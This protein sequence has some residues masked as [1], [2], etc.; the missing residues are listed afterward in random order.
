MN[1]RKLSEKDK[2]ELQKQFPVIE[3]KEPTEEKATIWDIA[4]MIF[5]IVMLGLVLYLFYL[6]WN[7]RFIGVW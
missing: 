4:I 6:V 7:Y 2:E 1:P 3:E 5:W